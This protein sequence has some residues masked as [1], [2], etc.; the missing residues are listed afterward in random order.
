MDGIILIDKPAGWTSFDVVNKVRGT[1]SKKLKVKSKKLK[2]GHAGTLDPFATGLLIV[3]IGK[4]CK[5]QD[6]FMGLDKT[7]EFT[8]RLG[9]TSTTGDTEGEI[10]DTSD[11]QPTEA[12]VKAAIKEFVGEIEQT[13]PVHSAIK[14]N[15]QRA[16]KLARAGKEVEMPTRKVMVHSLELTDYDYPEV[17]CVAKVSKGTYI[18]SLAADIGTLLEA[19]G[20]CSQLRRVSIDGYIIDSASQISELKPDIIPSQLNRDKHLA[21]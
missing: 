16:Y 18:R 17:K 6:E 5:Q 15:G 20:Y 14:I 19:G 11:K 7:Y 3:L 2:V 12:E 10:S 1:L 21:N 9:Q 13:P 4:A 8:I